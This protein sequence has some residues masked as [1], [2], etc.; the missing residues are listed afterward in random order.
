MYMCMRVH[1]YVCALRHPADYQLV[2]LGGRQQDVGYCKVYMY[3]PMCM[4]T[5]VYMHVYM[6][7]KRAALNPE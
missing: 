7:A 4:H 2:L 6:D 3:I 5:S 1:V